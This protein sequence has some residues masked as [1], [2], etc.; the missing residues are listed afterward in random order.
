MRTNK[1]IS[2]AFKLAAQ[3]LATASEIIAGETSG[4]T[5]PQTPKQVCVEAL[6]ERAI[7][8]VLSDGDS[9]FEVQNAIEEFNR[10]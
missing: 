7:F 5:G 2:E 9:A 4:H 3:Y 6:V 1:E 10:Q 8:V